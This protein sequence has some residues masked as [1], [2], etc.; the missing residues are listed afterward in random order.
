[1]AA[2]LGREVR[3][4]Q[5]WERREGL[6]VHRHHHE[7]S[8]TIYA[9]RSELDAWLAGRRRPPGA[10]EPAL[11]AEAGARSAKP[12]A[13]H[14]TLVALA[15]VAVASGASLG[16]VSPIPSRADALRH[17]STRSTAA[18]D[19]WRRGRHLLSRDTE[20]GYLESARSFAEAVHL[21]PGFAEAH[22]GLADAWLMLGRHGYRPPSETM[23]LAR[24]SAR[25]AQ[26]L[27]PGAPGL[28][29][30]LA[31]LLFYWD[32]DFPAAEAAYRRAIAEDPT[33]ARSHH[34]LAH[35]LSAMGRHAEALEASR[36]ARLLE[37]LSV[38]I[39]SDA[40]W[41][42]YRARRYQE[43]LAESRRA[44]ELEPGFGSALL[45]AVS[46]LAQRGEPGAAVAELRAAAVADGEEGILALLE[47]AD[48]EASLER[49]RRWRLE[50]LLHAE[51]Y[52]SPFSLAAAHASLGE[53]DAAF[54]LL[55]EAYASRDRAVLLL[56][57]NPGFDPLRDDPRFTEL[58]ARVGLEPAL[59]SGG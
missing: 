26:Q 32:W 34:G 53:I 42:L 20:R 31:G 41:F 50:R 1:V 9:Y 36:R 40:A 59:A 54:G 49:F 17:P 22:V 14:A 45:C 48:P 30:V 12:R 7:R 58:V 23:P 24:A 43:A 28:Q 11:A 47:G 29:A 27:D 25:E 38:A 2:Y 35:F 6:P 15:L 57:V 10:P 51:R 5:R 46:I 52:V 13:R 33:S 3:T 8:G 18:L 44:T 16:P 21:D 56:K 19:A 37:P 4:V 39:H 55:E